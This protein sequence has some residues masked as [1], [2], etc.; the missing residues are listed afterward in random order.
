MGIK[1][2]LYQDLLSLHLHY[3]AGIA[4]IFQLSSK[5]FDSNQ[6]SA[7]QPV[8]VPLSWTL[9]PPSAH[10]FLDMKTGNSNASLKHGL[11]PVSASSVHSAP[12]SIV[13]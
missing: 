5:R 9:M 4:C 1:T 11:I 8:E 6:S 3:K 12:V 13:L 7:M 10:S 2:E